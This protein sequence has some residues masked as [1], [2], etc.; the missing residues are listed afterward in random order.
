MWINEKMKSK[1]LYLSTSSLSIALFLLLFCS[2]SSSFLLRSV[3]GLS[4]LFL[5]ALLDYFVGQTEL[6]ILSLVYVWS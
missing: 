3:L 5:S 6:K 1:S 2:Q 4:Q